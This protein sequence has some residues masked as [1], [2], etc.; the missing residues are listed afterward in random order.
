[1]DYVFENQFSILS[2]ML[3]FYSVNLHKA[4]SKMNK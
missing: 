3:L 2:Y 4:L 1:M